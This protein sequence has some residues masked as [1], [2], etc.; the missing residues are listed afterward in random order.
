MSHEQHNPL[1]ES[2][3]LPPFSAIKPEHVVPGTKTLIADALAEAD[4]LSQ[5]DS[6]GWDTF[7]APLEEA[8]DR[9]NSAFSPVGHLNAVANSPE[10]RKAY[11]ETMPLLSEYSTRLGQH[12]GLFKAYQRLAD[13]PE[14]SQLNA[15]RQ[16]T[17]E[18][19]LRDF[20]LS[21]IDLPEEQQKRYGEI[22][23]RLSAITST[24]SNNVL[25]ATQAWT[26]RL[27]SADQ[28]PGV[29]E[30]SIELLA[31]NAEQRG[32]EGY[33]IT[34][35][36]PAFYPILNF[37]DDRALR[38]EVYVANSTKASETGPNGGEF[39]N[40]ALM[41]EILELRKE[42][43]EVLGFA[44]YAELSLA[45]K[46]AESTDQVVD[47]LRELATR[48]RPAAEQELAEL[49]AYAKEEL[50]IDSLE[51]WDVAYVSEKLRVARYA[52]SQ[53][54]LRPYFPVPKVIDGLF[55]VVERLYGIQVKE[56]T[57]EDTYHKDV[58]FYELSRDGQPIARFF[59]DLY[60][61]QGKRG[62]AWM[63][64]CRVRRQ[65]LDGSIQLPIAY[66]VCNFTPPVGNKKSLL[67]H[68]EVTT[69]FH[70]F[71]H[72]L[73]HM[74]TQV[75]VGSVS[76]INGV[77]WDAVELP[78]QFLENWCWEKEALDLMSGHYQTGEP[79]P[80]ELLDKML[81]AKNFQAAMMML[82]QIEF[83]LFDFLLHRDYQPAAE[84][85]P[86]TDVQAVLDSVRKE[87]AVMIPPSYN[88]F[89]HS[90]SHIF[91]GG[92][93]A[94]YYSYKWAE[95]LSADAFSAFEEEGIFNQATG[96]RFQE[97]IL[98]KGGSQPAME[99]FKAF[100]GREPD[101]EPLLR[102]SGLAA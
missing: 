51:A 93:A 74:L 28:L 34:L 92:Y 87:V 49:R 77:A 81:A 24:F 37:C 19:A 43:A 33:L 30:S 102:H 29:P 17:I 72:G 41:T 20:R 64:D 63:D 5:Q 50:G 48:S 4:R 88:R 47:F 73:H 75:D 2:H 38:E 85:K 67:T 97:C 83:A 45:T 32:Q 3:E 96:K 71:G 8:Y 76:G 59:L 62:G 44:N 69:L 86:G 40:S 10:L 56:L 57:L 52:I 82:R 68:N 99:L 26:K 78:S 46:M 95:V 91:A 22:S 7:V 61:R 36:F 70:E 79:L 13:S 27:D 21:G 58:S 54:D 31:Q 6:P 39:D 60:A 80:A 25:D 55:A 14:F 15:A 90:F 42:E 12:Q 101:I 18:H 65:R 1:L 16:A 11:D 35:D 100:R 9:L 94:G 23:Q 89:A 53:E 98:E 84:G 66:L